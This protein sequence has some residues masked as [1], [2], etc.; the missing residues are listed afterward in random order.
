VTGV[1]PYH[2]Y[3]SRPK[4]MF[5]SSIW[6]KFKKIFV[7]RYFQAC[8]GATEYPVPKE[9]KIGILVKKGKRSISNYEELIPWIESLG[10]PV[11]LIQP[12]E[13]D[14]KSELETIVTSSVTFMVPG[15]SSFSAGFLD[16]RSVAILI[17]MWDG[18]HNTSVQFESHWWETLG[19][20]QGINYILDKSEVLPPASIRDNTTLTD[21]ECGLIRV[22]F[23]TH[24]SALDAGQI[25]GLLAH[26][27]SFGLEEGKVKLI[28][29]RALKEAEKNY[30]WVDSYDKSKCVFA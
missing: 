1:G 3:M 13:T 28:V 4:H 18:S 9:Q 30:G 16:S 5:R 6:N 7:S 27:S 15:G 17:D 8:C 12:P 22:P 19:A 26:F 29:C 25:N 11:S 10:V 24:L 2:L 20:F 14:W 23:G 21:D